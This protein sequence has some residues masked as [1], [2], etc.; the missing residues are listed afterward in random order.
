MEWPLIRIVPN[1]EAQKDMARFPGGDM[2]LGD[3]EII[4]HSPPRHISP[5]YL[6]TTEVTVRSFK[7]VKRLVPAMVRGDESL[8]LQ[9]MMQ[10]YPQRPADFDD[11]AVRGV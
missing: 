10:D 11:Y 4:K 2:M 1:K 8:L 6:D 7:R 3:G 5:F 9:V